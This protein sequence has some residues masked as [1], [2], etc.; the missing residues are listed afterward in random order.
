MAGEAVCEAGGELMGDMCKR[1]LFLHNA[2]GE[3]MPRE[4]IAWQCRRHAPVSTAVGYSKQI[5]FPPTCLSGW[6]GDFRSPL[7]LTN[8]A[9]GRIVAMEPDPLDRIAKS[10]EEIALVVAHPVVPAKSTTP[11]CSDEFH[12][13]ANHQGTSLTCPRC[14]EGAAFPARCLNTLNTLRCHGEYGH[15]GICVFQAETTPPP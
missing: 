7:D 12:H 8:M 11:M 9:P 3:G 14:G 4:D 10:L 15:T 5:G 6:C 2:S 13:N 1:C